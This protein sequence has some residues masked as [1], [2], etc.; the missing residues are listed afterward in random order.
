MEGVDADAFMEDFDDPEAFFASGAKDKIL[1]DLQAATK[2]THN[3]TKTL[4]L[5][6]HQGYCL[7][8]DAANL[9]V[10]ELL[11][12][13]YTVSKIGLV[14]HALAAG[15]ETQTIA[16]HALIKS[17]CAQAP[18]AT[19]PSLQPRPSGSGPLPRSSN[20]TSDPAGLCC[21]IKKALFMHS[22]KCPLPS[23][24]KSF[25]TAAVALPQPP[26]PKERK[27]AAAAQAGLVQMVKSFPSAPPAA[28][29]HAQQV[30]S[31]AAI[32]AP[33][34][35]ERAKARCK[36]STTHSR[37]EVVVITSPPT[38]WPDKPVV[39]LLNSYLGS[40]GRAIRAVTET[41]NHLGGLALVCDVL[42]VKADIQ[43]MHTYFE[44][45]AK[46]I[47]EDVTTETQV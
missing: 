7:D 29:V 31:S 21:L 5:W 30:V 26:P 4:N 47:C 17:L 6:S 23:D 42:L 1:A 45:G 3:L 24:T 46:R 33:S 34:D 8:A 39:G 40:H 9:L 2:P 22:C 38:H 37:K 19:A 35:S 12:A 20:T 11:Q 14:Q 15:S 27:G 13:V 36:Q 43:V 18:P 32:V 10:T 44:A 28:I 25:A 41:Q 16:L